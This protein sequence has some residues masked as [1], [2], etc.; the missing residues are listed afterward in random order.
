MPA[1]SCGEAYC[2]LARTG[3]EVRIRGGVAG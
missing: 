2:G 3:R 1:V